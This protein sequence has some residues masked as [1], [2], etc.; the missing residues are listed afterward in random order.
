MRDQ[1][2]HVINDPDRA[3]FYLERENDKIEN[4]DV[5]KLNRIV[6]NDERF[7]TWPASGSK[8]QSYDGGLIVHTAQVVKT[9]L[10]IASD[11]PEVRHDVLF[12]A[13]VWHD[14]AK[15]WDYERS[16]EGWQ[17]TEFREVE[18]HLARSYADMR[19]HAV[20]IGLQPRFI[21]E[22][23]HIMLAHH[24]RRE[25]GSPVE[26]QNAAAW[27]LHAADMLSAYFVK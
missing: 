4:L 23:A 13:G 1:L 8:H 17:K 11:V 7:Q 22:V 26:P 3:I 6:I 27:A 12:T 19:H 5:Q 18:R 16:D 15:I 20:V 25:W 21:D 10:S 2:N 9:A 14:Y 24:G